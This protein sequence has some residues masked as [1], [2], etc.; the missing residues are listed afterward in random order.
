MFNVRDGKFMCSQK[1]LVR[2]NVIWITHISYIIPYTLAVISTESSQHT[3]TDNLYSLPLVTLWPL[4]G[5]HMRSG[6]Y[7]NSLW[8]HG[9]HSSFYIL[10]TGYL[11]GKVKEHT[12]TLKIHKISFTFR[13]PKWGLQYA[14]SPHRRVLLKHLQ[15]KISWGKKETVALAGHLSV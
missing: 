3:V 14:R 1:H 13:R 5:Y 8:L 15:R 2:D 6:N 7:F 4:V 12:W 9:C 11:K 10:S